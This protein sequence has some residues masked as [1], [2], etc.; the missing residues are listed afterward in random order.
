MKG[1]V[2]FIQK[3]FSAG[4]YFKQHIDVPVCVPKAFLN[5]T[6]SAGHSSPGGLIFRSSTQSFRVFFKSHH[7]NP[8]QLRNVKRRISASLPSH[9]FSG[10][11]S[12]FT[13]SIFLRT[14]PCWTNFVNEHQ[15]MLSF[16]LQNGSI[17]RG[18]GARLVNMNFTH[19]GMTGNA[20]SPLRG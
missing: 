18:L 7:S 14:F 2:D 8:L 16:L 20:N 5:K 13:H 3:A 11:F 1:D 6:H 15:I 4:I 10:L 19:L 9:A 17:P 12:Q